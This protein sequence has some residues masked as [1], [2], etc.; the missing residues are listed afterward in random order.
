MLWVGSV[1]FLFWVRGI[2]WM[3]VVF[4]SESVFWAF[5]IIWVDRVVWDLFRFFVCA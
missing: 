4:C 1:S 2:I 3:G 5:V